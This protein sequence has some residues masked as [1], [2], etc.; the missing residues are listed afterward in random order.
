[1]LEE[2][3]ASENVIAQRCGAGPVYTARVIGGQ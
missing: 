1:M 2:R 3:Q